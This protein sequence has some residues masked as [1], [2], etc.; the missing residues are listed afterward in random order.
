MSKNK[1]R[2]FAGL[3]DRFRPQ[4]EHGPARPGGFLYKP[5]SVRSTERVLNH[6]LQSRLRHS[7]PKLSMCLLGVFFT[8]RGLVRSAGILSLNGNQ[9]SLVNNLLLVFSGVFLVF[10]SL[11]EGH[12]ERAHRDSR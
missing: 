5:D 2:D 3:N 9:S 8:G 10:L 6:R 12:V 4:L 1:G 11:H 7:W